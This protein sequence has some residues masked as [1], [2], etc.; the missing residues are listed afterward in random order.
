MGFETSGFSI[1]I[2][3]LFFSVWI[4]FISLISFNN[5]TYLP[6]SSANTISTLLPLSP[7]CSSESVAILTIF[8]FMMQTLSERLD[9]SSRL[10]VQRKTVVFSFFKLSMKFLTIWALSGSSPAVGSSSS[11]ILG[12][13]INA[14]DS[15]SFCFIPLE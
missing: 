9:A 4:F 5:F 15:A 14:L 8:F 6:A 2:I 10:W 12:S 11:S 7:L 3:A 1:I 13:C